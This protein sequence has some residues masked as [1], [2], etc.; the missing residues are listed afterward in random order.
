MID[1]RGGERL[2]RIELAHGEAANPSGEFVLTA[3]VSASS[4]VT[5]WASPSV[6]LKAAQTPPAFE[7]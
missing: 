3:A 1:E 5:F 4:V 6:V 7:K 2:R